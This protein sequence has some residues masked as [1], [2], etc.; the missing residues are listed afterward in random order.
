M[1]VADPKP[2]AIVICIT[3][4]DALLGTDLPRICRKA[5]EEND[6]LVIP[7]YMY[8]IE[9]EGNIIAT[10]GEVLTYEVNAISGTANEPTSISFVPTEQLPQEGWT[11][12]QG[13]K[14]P[15]RPTEK[16]IY[17]YNGRKQLIK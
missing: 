8:A 16:G 1:E 14:L 11:T 2:K 3:C 13:I 12:L 17:I 9:R 5:E 10:T 4:V 15:G 6:V 7:S